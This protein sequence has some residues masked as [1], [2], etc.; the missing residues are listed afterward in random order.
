MRHIETHLAEVD[1]SLVP[2]IKVREDLLYEG[3][4]RKVQRIDE[5]LVSH[6]TPAHTTHVDH[7]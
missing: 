1:K 6:N 5:V 2:E 4:I 7:Q 3:T